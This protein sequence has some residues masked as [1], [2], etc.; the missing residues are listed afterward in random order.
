MVDPAWFFST[1]AQATAASIGF[2]IAFLA[3]LYTGRKNKTQGN[4]RE[5]MSQLQQIEANYKPLLRRMEK[6]MTG[7]TDFP[8]AD[9]TIEKACEIDLTQSEIEDI[10]EEYEQSTAVKMWAN[11]N[12]SQKILDRL[13]LPQPNNKKIEHITRLNETSKDMLTVP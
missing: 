2:L 12:R 10:A 5:F 11:L 4:Y 13:I 3:A 7:V 9:G 6:Q 8:V 1:L